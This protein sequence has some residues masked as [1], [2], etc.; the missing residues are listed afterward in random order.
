M[1]TKVRAARAFLEPVK[2]KF[3]GISYSDLW[4]LAAYVGTRKYQNFTNTLTPR[5]M[6]APRF[7]VSFPADDPTYFGTSKES[8]CSLLR[9][10]RSGSRQTEKSVTFLGSVHSRS[11]VMCVLCEVAE[12]GS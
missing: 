7:F 11:T 8:V 6:A 12:V 3:P 2:R 1:L 9:V 10:P 4:I 5:D